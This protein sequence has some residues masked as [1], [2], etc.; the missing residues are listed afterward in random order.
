MGKP[1]CV[2]GG[3]TGSR[4]RAEAVWRKSSHST[5]EG[6]CVEVAEPSGGRVLFR[7][8]KV[9]QGP[10]V[11]VSRGTAAAFITAVGRGAL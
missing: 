10:V 1:T 9:R 3:A 2:R 11:P 5:P 8:S 7:D 6:A 4:Q